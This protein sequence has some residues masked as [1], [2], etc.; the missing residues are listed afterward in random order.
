MTDAQKL[1]ALVRRAKELGAESEALGAYYDLEGRGV[2]VDILARAILFDAPVAR[3]LFGECTDTMTVQNNSL[4]VKQ[5][6]DMN[7]WRYHLQQAV[8]S[9][10]P[11]DYMYKAV[12]G[13]NK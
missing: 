11:I 9:K 7:G 3:A 1:E 13:D 6:I 2:S 5:V 10:D 12:F 4:N 8:I